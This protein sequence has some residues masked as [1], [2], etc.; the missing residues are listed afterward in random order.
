M[1]IRPAKKFWLHGNPGGKVLSTFTPA[2]LSPS[3]WIEPSQSTMFQSNVGSGT[4][5]AANADPVGY[6]ADLSGNGFHLTSAADDATRPTLQGVGVKP[7]LNFTSA[8]VQLLLRLASTGMYAAGAAS[9][10]VAMRGQGA[11]GATVVGEFDTG[12][13]NSRYQIILVQSTVSTQTA[14]IRNSA[15]TT[16][17]NNTN[18][19]F[20]N[21][22]STTVDHV[23][24]VADSGTQLTGY[25]DGTAGTP[26]S[27]TRSGTVTQNKFQLSSGGLNNRV[28][29]LVCVNR[30]LSGSEITALN[31]YLAGKF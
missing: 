2:S 28:Y 21:A 6:I 23:N 15:N 16:T 20:A 9:V 24:G 14:L 29:A 4:A 31:A 18:A 1:L 8:G 19:L 5:S 17:F 25:L 12:S 30:V 3:L 26:V 27:Y 13:A 22:F 10:F 11:G 7:Y